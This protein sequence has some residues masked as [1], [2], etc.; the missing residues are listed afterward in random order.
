MGSPP[1]PEE[2]K[3]WIADHEAKK[4]V[5][6]EET[7]NP[8]VDITQKDQEA[9]DQ[10]GGPEQEEPLDSDVPTPRPFGTSAS[11]P[12]VLKN[13]KEAL[14]YPVFYI[15]MLTGLFVGMNGYATKG[16]L[17]CWTRNLERCRR[18]LSWIILLLSPLFD[19]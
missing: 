19:N 9:L 5:V 18:C 17:W 2:V 6:G 3:A 1:R 7:K 14:K 12:V 15:N 10:Q 16:M 4:E 11:I 8:E 13:R